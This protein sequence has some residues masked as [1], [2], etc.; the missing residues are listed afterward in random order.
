MFGKIQVP[1][2]RDYTA[3]VVVVVT[4]LRSNRRE[5]TDGRDA[6]DLLEIKRAHCK[7]IDSNKDTWVGVGDAQR[8]AFDKLKEENKLQYDYGEMF[9]PQI[10]IDGNY[11]GGATE[12][13]ELEDTELLEAFLLRTACPTCRAPRQQDTTNCKICGTDFSEI[14][15]DAQTID[16]ALE[17]FD[18]ESSAED[19]DEEDNDDEDEEVDESGDEQF[20]E[21]KLLEAPR[22]A[23]AK[24][25]ADEELKSVTMPLHGC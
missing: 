8:C 10:F 25:N 13:Q 14:L 21:D 18:E 17:V 12:L 2:S 7:V 5:F 15:P 23:T 24:I 1:P 3:E 19:E 4:T 6:R 11:I 20:E 16:E 9:F 22:D